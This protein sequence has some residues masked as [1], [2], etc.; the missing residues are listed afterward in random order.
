MTHTVSSERKDSK[1]WEQ[2]RLVWFGEKGRVQIAQIERSVAKIGHFLEVEKMRR[3]KSFISLRLQGRLKID[4]TYQVDV[5]SEMGRVRSYEVTEGATGDQTRRVTS[6]SGLVSEQVQSVD[7]FST[8]TRPDGTTIET[9][10]VPDPRFGLQAPYVEM[11]TVTTPGGLISTIE[12]SRSVVLSDPDNPLSLLSLSGT[13][14]VNGRTASMDYDATTRE[15]LTTSPEGRQA[16]TSFDEDGRV[17]EVLAGGLVPVSFSY[18]SYGRPLTV[19]QGSG[20]DARVVTYTYYPDGTPSVGMVESVTDPLLRTVSFEYDEV[21]R[22]VLQTLPDGR[23]IGFDYDPNGNVT[24]ITPPGRPDHTFNYTPFDLG[25][26]YDPPDVGVVP[27]DTQYFYNDDRQLT[28]VLRPDGQTIDF[29][30]NATTGRLETVTAPHGVTNPT[31]DPVTGNVTSVTGPGGEILSYVY[32]G[33][34][35]TDVTWSGTVS[36]TVSRE[37]DNNFRTIS[38]TVNGADTV[39][40]DHDDDGLL[41]QAG[42]LVIVRDLVTGFIDTTTLGVVTTDRTYSAFGELDSEVA[43]VG[44]VDVLSRV[45]GRDD[46]GRIVSITETVG[47]TTTLSEYEYDLVGRLWQVYE[48]GSLVREYEYDDNGNRLSVTEAPLSMSAS[49]AVPEPA[50][51][52]ASDFGVILQPADDSGSLLSSSSSGTAIYDDQDRLLEINGTTYDYTANGELLSRTVG[53]VDTTYYTYDVYGNLVTV[54]LPDATVI[55]YVIDPGNRRIGRV[56]DGF[57]EQGFLY[58]DG[59]NPVAELD[60]TGAVVSRFVYGTRGNLPEYMVRGGVTYRIITDHL[61]SVRLVVDVSSGTIVQ[62]MVYDEWGNVL[63]DT[64][65]GFTPFGFAGGIYDSDTGLVRFGARD[66]DPEVGR[67]TSKDPIGFRSGANFF[68]YVGNDPV[69]R[70]DPNGLGRVYV[71]HRVLSRFPFDVASALTGARHSA[72]RFE[73]DDGRTVVISGYPVEDRFS[74]GGGL[75]LWTYKEVEQD[76]AI[77]NW[78]YVGEVSDAIMQ[79]VFEYARALNETNRPPY[80]LLGNEGEYNCNSLT[81]GIL[82]ALDLPNPLQV[83]NAPGWGYWF[84]GIDNPVPISTECLAD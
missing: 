6:S 15:L 48:D 77:E 78:I 72:V 64:N 1:Y 70:I 18:D 35:L 67:F 83:C 8:L 22:V 11:S 53:G 74:D 45:Y 63:V 33:S 54:E 46:L 40:F 56:V 23:Q 7:D 4:H 34:L 32:D 52:M 12:S 16:L 73:Y 13:R 81:A 58:R 62:E 50:W 49:S 69:N 66:Y 59:L 39:L 44:G 38:R 60:G 31:Y 79:L 29:V 65:P 75:E 24:V 26:Q 57:L 17:I 2:K 68:V 61:G 51:R 10:S 82:E 28:Q 76:I 43:Q 21:G 37:F 41:T 25:E 47:G 36:G 80:G 42:N 3:C 55:D 19:T 71:G 84:P 14:T 30:Y 20:L 27:D 9:F 5:T